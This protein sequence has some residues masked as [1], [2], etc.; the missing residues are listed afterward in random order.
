MPRLPVDLSWMKAVTPL[1][2]RMTPPSH[3]SWS[4]DAS[5]VPRVVSAGL[6]STQPTIQSTSASPAKSRI[7]LSPWQPSPDPTDPKFDMLCTSPSS[8]SSIISRAFQSWGRLR[9][10]SPAPNFMPRDRHSSTIRSAS[11]SDNDTGFSHRIAPTPARAQAITT[12][13]FTLTGRMGATM[14]SC[15]FASTSL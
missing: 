12:S 13:E 11:S 3:W 6:P 5:R 8:P 1:A 14:S 2:N 9:N 15:S 4:E 7:T 10:M